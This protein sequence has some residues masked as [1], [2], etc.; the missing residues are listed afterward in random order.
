MVFL[1][2]ENENNIKI[3]KKVFNYNISI[4]I[5]YS[6]YDI[7]DYLTQKLDFFN[8]FIIK[9]REEWEDL[10]KIKIPKITFEQNDEDKFQNGCFE[11]AET[12]DINLIRNK[13][14]FR[15]ENDIDFLSEFRKDIYYIYKEHN[16]LDIFFK[17]NC[18][19]FGWKL[20]PELIYFNICFVKR[21]LYM[22]C[23]EERP[24]G[25]NFYRFIN[26]DLKSRDPRKIYRYINI[27][28]LI[29]QLIEEGELI[30][31]KG[32]VYRATILDEKL[33]LKLIPGT[34]MVNTSFWST[35]KDKQIAEGFMLRENWR[36]S[37][38]VCKTVKN[39]IDLQQLNPYGEKEILLLPFSEF[40]VEK[41]SSEM[42][43]GKK[44]YTIELTELE[45]KN[46]VRPENM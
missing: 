13:Y 16:A 15:L 45:N 2:I 22:Y 1:Y 41:I 37:F 30:N 35:S 21:F 46:F 18:L 11:L 26:D 31:F 19:Y 40:I 42:K 17:Q 7:I 32:K 25:K 34:K 23:R 10:L 6:P 39:N 27:L 3:K 36:N 14:I 20:Y 28:A 5:V 24:S 43:N 12:F 29:N 38:I 8:P 4:I 33:I 9:Q 44:K